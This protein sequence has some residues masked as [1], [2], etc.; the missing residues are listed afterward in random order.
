MSAAQDE[1][2][3]LVNNNKA[4]A[5]RP[6]RDSV[7]PS[8]SPSPSDQ[9]QD[10]DSAPTSNMHTPARPA[11]AH[12]PNTVYDANTGPKGVIADAQAF[13]RA[14]KTSARKSFLSAVGFNHTSSPPPPQPPHREESPGGS[15]EDDDEFM[16]R[17]RASRM[18]ELAGNA[19]GSMQR[20]SPRR[21]VYGT[22]EDVDAEEYLDAIEK[23]AAETVVVVCIYD[24][25]SNPSATVEDCLD[26]L[27]PQF[28]LVRFVKLHY[29]I[30]A[31]DHVDPPALLAYR[32]AEVF[33]TLVDIFA[34]IPKGRSCTAESLGDLLKAN[35]VL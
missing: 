29:E 16:R 21:R 19:T 1:F 30:A 31:M 32:G 11:A 9:D 7:S 8:P 23:V 17:W 6:N 20:S 24:P 28:P 27:A 34:A 5:N 4:T 14:R 26:A 22:V 13:E 3:A 35:R 18:Q 33:V 15:E 12:I 10:Q 25:E 2:N